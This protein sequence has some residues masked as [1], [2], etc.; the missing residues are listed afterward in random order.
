MSA[1]I[2]RLSWDDLRIVRA[3]AQ[4]G[5]L[6]PAAQ[7]LG[8]NG[9]T[10][11]RRLAKVEQV[12][13]TALFDRRRTGYVT[14]VQGEEIVALAERIELDVV[15]VARRVSGHTQGHAGDLHI[16]TSDSILLYFLTPM[17]ASFKALNPAVNM[18]V[19]V[20]NGALNLARGESDIA[21]RATKTPPEN[22][23]GRKVATIAWAPYAACSA[24]APPL[25]DA[26]P[27]ADR[28]W[29]SYGGMLSGL[30]AAEF[31]DGRVPRD[32][33]GYR[34]DSVAG[35]AA[36]IA[37]GLGVGYL[38]CMLGDLSPDIERVGPVEPALTDDLWLLT[39]PDIRRSGRVYAF[40]SHCIEAIGQ[41][42]ELVEGRLERPSGPSGALNGPWRPLRFPAVP[43]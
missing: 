8:L 18:E 19:T 39:H 37:A 28:Q 21:I 42:R 17:I 15:S 31:V 33:I 12:L 11:A 6:A 23:F 29:V 32:N 1:L 41:H 26:R 14:T 13:G 40:M 5:A 16:T 3:I 20:G 30:T 38:P 43:Q 2:S 24:S 36:A 27:M 9:S 35:A 10:I 22:L 34:T 25:S 7:M 4:N